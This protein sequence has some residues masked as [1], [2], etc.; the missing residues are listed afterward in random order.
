MRKNHVG[1][2]LLGCLAPLAGLAAVFVFKVRIPTV[3]YLG[4]LV[5]CPVSHILMMGSMGHDHAGD[6]QSRL[7]VNH[8]GE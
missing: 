4:L 5:L 1:I 7:H 3:L 2:M 8:A 6:G